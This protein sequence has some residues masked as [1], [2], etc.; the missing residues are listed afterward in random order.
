MKKKL[1]LLLVLVLLASTSHAIYR[2][3]MPTKVIQPNGD[4]V[5]CFITG[6]EYYRWLHDENFYT[7]VQNPQNGYYVYADYQNV[8]LIPTLLLAGKDD[9]RNILRPGINHS[10]EKINE[11]CLR[12]Q[13]FA[14]S[15]SDNTRIGGYTPTSGN[16]S[17]LVIYIAFAYDYPINR[18]GVVSSLHNAYNGYSNSLKS[19]Y[20]NVSDDKLNL[21]SVFL[22][23]SANVIV[24]YTD[25][26]SRYF[27]QPKSAYNPNGYSGMLEMLYRK[28]RLFYR[29]IHFAVN[30]AN[31]H[32]SYDNNWTD[33]DND[34]NIDN[35]TF[36]LNGAAE[37]RDDDIFWPHYS[38]F[39]LPTIVFIT[40]KHL[41]D[42]LKSG[43]EWACAKSYCVQMLDDIIPPDEP[44]EANISVLCHE[45]FHSL[46]APDLYKYNFFAPDPVEY[47]DLMGNAYG[48]QPQQ[49][50]GWMKYKYG[51][52]INEIPTITE[53][54]MYYMTGS[55]SD[56]HD[57]FIIKTPNSFNQFFLL[58]YRDED[59]NV[60][61][62]KNSLVVHRIDSSYNGNAWTN[63]NEIF[64]LRPFGEEATG[65]GLP[66]MAGISRQ[67]I[68]K[69]LN[70]YSQPALKYHSLSHGF[71]NSHVQIDTVSM[72]SKYLVKFYVYFLPYDLTSTVN[73]QQVTLNWHIP[74]D[75][76]VD[77]YKIYRNNALIG[78]SQTNSYVDIPPPGTMFSYSVSAVKY[79]P[80]TYTETP[81]TQPVKVYLATQSCF[82]DTI[83]ETNVTIGPGN[84]PICN[85]IDVKGNGVLTIEPG[86]NLLFQGA[87]QIRV[88]DYGRIIAEGTETDS[89][90]FIWDE[91]Y[92]LAREGGI[93]FGSI[94][95][96]MSL[97][98]ENSI[99]NYCTF[100][101]FYNPS[102]LFMKSGLFILYNFGKISIK[103]CCF[104]H[105]NV[106]NLIYNE[107]NRSSTNS[108]EF[109]ISNNKFKENSCSK[110]YIYQPR[111]IHSIVNDTSDLFYKQVNLS[112]ENNSFENN[113]SDKGILSIIG[114][115][116]TIIN[117]KFLN[118]SILDLCGPIFQNEFFTS[119]ITANCW[120]NLSF[121][122]N[123]VSNN[124]SYANIA[125][126]FLGS[127]GAEQINFNFL[128]S[129]NVNISDNLI[130]NN[131]IYRAPNP[132]TWGLTYSGTLAI[133]SNSNKSNC[134]ITSNT[135]INNRPVF[136]LPPAILN[137]NHAYSNISLSNGTYNMFN[138]IIGI[139]DKGDINLSEYSEFTASGIVNMG[140]CGIQGGVENINAT[141][142]NY[143]N[144]DFYATC[145]E[146]SADIY[147]SIF[148]N[149]NDTYTLANW[150]LKSYSIMRNSGTPDTTGLTIPPF[151]LAGKQRI[152]DNRID[153]G[154]Y[155]YGESNID[156][157]PYS[158]YA[159]ACEGAESSKSVHITNNG[160]D[161]L[162][163]SCE[164]ENIQFAPYMQVVGPDNNDTTYCIPRLTGGN[165]IDG[166]HLNT[167]SNTG[168]Y[169]ANHGYIDFTN[170]STELIAGKLYT[171]TITSDRSGSNNLWIDYD[172]NGVFETNE[173]LI[174]NYYSQ[175][176]A[177]IELMVPESA[178]TSYCT[179]LRFISTHN[180][181][182]DPCIYDS[183]YSIVGT[184]E[185][186]TVSIIGKDCISLLSSQPVPPYNSI[187][188]SLKFNADK[189]PPGYLTCNL[190]FQNN[191]SNNPN[192]SR[193]A[194]FTINPMPIIQNVYA[195]IVDNDVTI[196]WSTPQSCV[197]SGF[198]L[199]RNGELYK[200]NLTTNS[201][202]DADLAPGIYSYYVTCFKDLHESDPSNTA[203][204]QFGCF[205]AYNIVNDTVEISQS[206]AYICDNINIGNGGV[207]KINPGSK[208]VFNGFY[209]IKLSGTGR[210]IAQGT[211]ADSIT[212][213]VA[214]T[215]GFSN[216]NVTN[217][218]WHGIRFGETAAMSATADS[219]LFS[220]CRF[221]Y[222]KAPTLSGLNKG[223]AFF[224][225]DYSQ[226]NIK[227]CLFDKCYGQI[228]GAVY[229]KINFEY[230]NASIVLKNNLFKNCYV[231]G[232]GIIYFYSAKQLS[233]SSL[234]I[235]S[236]IVSNNDGDAIVVSGGWS[237]GFP[238]IVNNVISGNTKFGIFISG[239]TDAIITGNLIT[240]NLSAG[241]YTWSASV[242]ISLN[243]I[244][245]NRESGIQIHNPQNNAPI[246]SNLIFNNQSS[247][248]GGGIYVYYPSGSSVANFT[249]NT[250]VNNFAVNSGGGFY[251]QSEQMIFPSNTK[252]TSEIS[253]CILWGNQ[254]TSG[255]NQAHFVMSGGYISYCCIQDSINGITYSDSLVKSGFSFPDCI[256]SNPLF[257]N[258]TSNSGSG[259]TT[260]NGLHPDWSLQAES[261]CIDNGSPW[262]YPI[263]ESDIAGNPRL[264]G[265][266]IDIGSY[267]F[268]NFIFDPPHNLQASSNEDDITL[269]W[270]NIS[271][272]NI[273]GFNIYRNGLLITDS[274]SAYT[275]NDEGMD[276][277]ITYSY[278]VSTVYL[279]GESQKC[280]PISEVC[281]CFNIEYISDSL[282]VLPGTYY[283]CNNIYIK[284]GGF[285]KLLPGVQFKF[286]DLY[287][288][289]VEGT[290]KM[291]A[292][293][294]QTDSIVLTSV[295]NYKEWHGIRFGQ[296]NPMSSFADTSIFSFCSISHTNYDYIS[297]DD[298]YGNAFFI[299]NYSKV[300]IQNSN[301]H[302]TIDDFICL[303]NSSPIIRYCTISEQISIKN[304]SSP[305][306]TCNLFHRGSIA[307][308]GSSPQIKGNS[309]TDVSF[310]PI[311][312]G[313]SSPIISHNTI[314]G[315]YGSA[316]SLVNCSGMISENTLSG[317]TTNSQGP[318]IKVYNPN[319]IT[320]LDTLY[321]IENNIVNNYT[322]NANNGA[323]A[324][325]FA[326]NVVIVN[327]TIANNECSGIYCYNSSPRII[328]TL[329]SNNYS[330]NTGMACAMHLASG[331]P[332][333]SYCLIENGIYGIDWWN[334]NIIW[335]GGSFGATC[336][337]DQAEFK[338]PTIT[339]G[340][341]K[342]TANGE[343]PD[344]SPLITSPVIDK[345]TPNTS[346]LHLDEYDFFGHPRIHNGRID[347]GSIEFYQA[348]N[349]VIELTYND[350]EYS[351]YVGQS[352]LDTILISN[353]GL[354]T[355][356]CIFEIEN[357]Q[358]SGSD[359]WITLN[360]SDCSIPYNGTFNLVM[361]INSEWSLPGP[362]EAIL[363]IQ[364]NSPDGTIDI[365]ISMFTLFAP[366]PGNLDGQI[367]GGNNVSL[368]WETSQTNE[369]SGFNVYR[370]D[371]LIAQNIL[372]P[373][374]YDQN[375]SN[376][377]QNYYVTCIYPFW[378]SFSSNDYD[379]TLGCWNQS[380]ITSHVV[381]QPGIYQICSDIV[382]ESNGSLSILPGTKLDFYGDAEIIVSGNGKIN[383]IGNETDSI[384]F[385]GFRSDMG[386]K[387]ISFGATNPM[388]QST[389]SSIFKFCRF[390]RGSAFGETESEKCGGA[391]YIKDF[392][393]LR[394]QN[395][396]FNSGF[397][398]ENGS[399][400]FIKSESDN[401]SPIIKNCMFWQNK[402]LMG[403]G[404]ICCLSDGSNCSP[405]IS[406]NTFDKNTAYYGSAIACLSKNG[407]CEP[408]IQLN[409]FSN[410]VSEYEGS[411]YVMADYQES[412]CSPH[413]INN[414]FIN[415]L[416]E[417]G[418][419][420][421][422]VFNDGV[423]NSKIFNNTICNNFASSNGGGIYFS[424]Y[425]ISSNGQCSPVLLNNIIW[426]NQ[427]FL[428]S[429]IFINDSIAVSINPQIGFCAVQ[430][431]ENDIFNS[432][433]VD[434]VN[435]SF[436][437]TC[438]TLD[439][440]NSMINGPNFIQ[441]SAFI[442]PITNSEASNW[443][444][445]E[446]SGGIDSGITS[447]P[448][449]LILNEDLN[450][451]MRTIGDEIDM[452]AYEYGSESSYSINLPS[453]WSGVS[454]WF[455]P[456]YSNIETMFG[457]LD[458]NLI[459]LLNSNG[460]YWPG[461]NINTIGNWNTHQG[462]EIKMTGSANLNLG[463]SIENDMTLMLASGWNL[464]PV[465]S[466]YNV[467]VNQLFNQ[468]NVIIVK[469][470]AGW[471]LYWPTFNIYTLN[472]L[473][474]GK[475]YYVRMAAAGS[476]TF[477]ANA[478][479]NGFIPDEP[480]WELTT[481]WNNI[482]RN[483]GSHIF[484]IQ[485]QALAN[486]SKEDIIGIFTPDGHC[487]GNVQVANLNQ[488]LALYAYADDQL[489]G[490]TDGFTDGQ[491]MIFKLFRPSTGEEFNLDV[492][493]NAEMLNYDGLFATEGISAISSISVLSTGISEGSTSDLHIFPNP[494]T[495]KVTIGGITGIE[496]IIVISVDGAVVM[497][498]T[499]KTEGDQVLDLSDLKA[500][501]YQVQ[502][503][504]S[505]GLVTRKV[506]KGL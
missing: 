7:I 417:N 41:T 310:I 301:F 415:N 306:I 224:I 360:V 421:A 221:E 186:Y 414:L 438:L 326:S 429:Q 56:P 133:S 397:S 362:S 358:S 459:I 124:S 63:E 288:I 402:S 280:N 279:Q 371:T 413:I 385:T 55:S 151:D 486:L 303:D 263:T 420:I 422:C 439:S 115:K 106:T 98:S 179:R 398:I 330:A 235:Q 155:E 333:I 243:I 219:S 75:S 348:T 435:G 114:N 43:G 309:F 108:T 388:Q 215:T 16:V 206:P 58:E 82:Q 485:Q 25:S 407:V 153:I 239:N 51:K 297:I 4:T 196:H 60:H 101:N 171:L 71:Q 241:I 223:G 32:N 234:T 335:G 442:G 468:T 177:T 209:S 375:V 197:N 494:T 331:N 305:L 482:Q 370:N 339:Y 334:G 327:N 12:K 131:I 195:T 78:T 254:T 492:V 425:D 65:T 211:E 506:V 210:I 476:V 92:N 147:A 386:W 203:T 21:N 366:S 338:N 345:G 426:N 204:L 363:H 483:A 127:M 505:Q 446:L 281:G 474:P 62:G 54:G 122:G 90:R 31:A 191:S 247:N 30:W 251:A 80:Y 193:S 180:D 410:N 37:S 77:H 372:V 44:D 176:G 79:K 2:R 466:E 452:G 463:G 262:V 45:M 97:N 399:A 34:G 175:D 61:Y 140:Y 96:E 28:E 117:N 6:D 167:I 181:M 328:N 222:G 156:L 336:L 307:S 49:M 109:I 404:T 271:A 161:Y 225:D 212:F 445:S 8:S 187:Y 141:N 103:N 448:D 495:G 377:Y 95:F 42:C 343:E 350:L 283:I 351:L 59:E 346:G 99:F 284:N 357:L 205:N 198:R 66:S 406:G 376:G 261:Q 493:Y 457:Q 490:E 496:E 35:I 100:S 487:V 146:F 119:P 293:G 286:T 208:L 70:D 260:A 344:W 73:G 356:N 423:T 48:K 53:T 294:S 416:A 389:D 230:S 270:E 384:I 318:A 296:T 497:R 391:F 499:P 27:Y 190:K 396:A 218:S 347:I 322:S 162:T 299:K 379:T 17:P 118:N 300:I 272:S 488:N 46:G 200:D 465:L 57:C 460:L 324:L 484:A 237:E 454:T 120:S 157:W 5:R 232:S 11:I 159:N 47:W 125:M 478:A 504:T 332:K 13:Q 266:Q 86:T 433:Y 148:V 337:N 477:P 145:E 178:P 94:E 394:I 245:N 369:L 352:T 411:I 10:K 74:D 374:Y 258:P 24:W 112:I 467:D 498:F 52:W 207:L 427:S 473:T 259:G 444:L 116:I 302:N 419:A 321:I 244:A 14:D 250:I 89:I 393:R 292:I 69:S 9:P 451:K 123:I 456:K 342:P 33:A 242:N 364:T 359:N 355:L 158:F 143:T 320:T 15:L 285:L 383:A 93:C 189:L 395:C 136:H 84:V 128:D 316:I 295:N 19:Y 461:Q 182:D 412:I 150:G 349:P 267:E 264:R 188:T 174:Q 164:M 373:T 462:Y 447:F 380:V 246:M 304:G 240:N 381:L 67:N 23:D 289:Y 291:E 275:F 378:E 278:E 441:P 329:F 431:P 132:L 102:I 214:D 282:I 298:R 64:T 365:P 387:G 185:D 449:L 253:D 471:K 255:N 491:P 434:Y 29:A 311:G 213:T 314:T 107:F 130:S 501:F 317:N 269:T 139:S 265:Y 401:C 202:L 76:I 315:A 184:A 85:D 249:N 481:P 236:N 170:Y 409:K 149:P 390:D 40:E 135:V 220:H 470:V 129:C 464:I 194:S 400:I 134:F 436:S 228:G 276:V 72:Q 152:L 341:N 91:N 325:R 432:K 231:M 36:I 290:G 1:T 368:E 458:E 104:Y 233:N 252:N 354:E 472:Q 257:I 248:N 479:D 39:I 154:A 173:W 18:P 88:S 500:G 405:V 163:Y 142:I 238:L 165:R 475:A 418:G 3:K 455:R 226:L 469:E 50:N 111:T 216:I 312:C 313:N 480:I 83:V 453:G 138:N 308:S 22:N 274:V 227:N 229:G 428:G 105:N 172:E 183:T 121:I 68:T 217:G 201:Y 110:A 144:G 287:A 38:Q 113:I 268:M 361:I 353:S 192:L 340:L 277:G 87:A 489:T 424:Y 319:M 503:R 392:S 126:L 323:L 160:N 169:I 408:S 168:N 502:I 137:D 430:N 440:A 256:Y 443:E 81:K 450:G 437:A 403:Y 166:F 26:E 20:K 367:V 273:I 199:Y 382:I